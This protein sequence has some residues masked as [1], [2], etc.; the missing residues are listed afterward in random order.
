VR[1]RVTASAAASLLFLVGLSLSARPAAAEG[2][3]SSFSLV[4]SVKVATVFDDNLLLSDTDEESSFGVWVQPRLELAYRTETLD[5]GADLGADF[6]RYADYYSELADELWHASGH[7]QVGILPGLTLRVANAFVPSPVELGLPEDE[8]QNLVQTNRTD[9]DLR[10]WRGLPGEREIGF[11]LRGTR[12]ASDDYSEEIPGAGG[13]VILDDDFNADYWGGIGSLEYREPL[14]RRT[15]AYLRAQGGYRAIDEASRS[16]NFDYSLLVGLHSLRFRNTEIDVA[17]GY[18]RI[19]FASLGEQPRILGRANLRYRTESGWSWRIGVNHL[20]SADLLGNAAL[21]T[22]GSLGIEKRFADGRTAAGVTLF[23][24]RFDT[25]SWSDGP[26]L[27]GGAEVEVRRQL[28]RRVQVRAAYRH[29]HNRGGYE[30][31]DLLQ[32][33]LKLELAFRY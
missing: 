1:H 11:G 12:F 30:V 20:S 6:R 31:D 32:N 2:Q 18:G 22:T 5:V 14:G 9:V 29:W 15:A 21:E 19:H 17:G 8:G 24:T 13:S 7:A 16:D 26:N 4:P 10:Y 27:F 25:D 3:P 33:R 23:L 28:T